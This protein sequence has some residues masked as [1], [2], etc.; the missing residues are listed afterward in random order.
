MDEKL[1]KPITYGIYVRKSSESEDKQVQSL[2]RQKTELKEIIEREGLVVHGRIFEEKQSAFRTGR[3]AFAELVDATRRGEVN[4]WLCWHANRLSRNPVDGGLIVHLMDEG[5]LDHIRTRDKVYENTPQD[6]LMLHIEFGLSKNDSEE[7]SRIV[8]SGIRRRQERGYPNGFPPVGF[9]LAGNYGSSGR[10]FWEIDKPQWRILRRIFKKFLMGHDSVLTIFNFARSAGLRSLARNKLGGRSPSRSAIHRLLVNPIYA[11][12]FMARN[13]RRYELAKELPRL[14]TEEEHERIRAILGDHNVA[15]IKTARKAAFSG[16]IHTP[17]GERLGVD[18]KFHLRCDCDHKFSYIHR[19]HCPKCEAQIETL[20]RPQYRTYVY[21]YS[22]A[23][24]RRAVRPIRSIEERE[25]RELARKHI[26]ENLVLPRNVKQWAVRYL[27]EL[28]DEAL[29]NRQ[30]EA[31]RQKRFQAELRGK[32]SKLTELYLDGLISKEDYEQE[33][34]SLA[35]AG[36][37]VK[38]A[39]DFTLAVDWKVEA[40]HIL[41]LAEEMDLILTHGNAGEVHQAMDSL[42]IRMIWDGEHLKFKHATKLRRLIALIEQ[43]RQEGL[44]GAPG[45][46][47]G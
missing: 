3:N 31:E 27:P 17:D 45:K 13:G 30:R 4:A 2:V 5:F 38:E 32:R 16:L 41:D 35:M 36:A 25:V 15:K 19:T 18:H 10:S 12:Y 20:K 23:S 39:P 29:R 33:A 6:K 34:R 14:I 46:C 28:Q 42:G 43:G 47:N 26:E 1:S 37:R 22:L 21:Y 9:K 40:V 44:V 24:R 11:G 7:K 8:Q